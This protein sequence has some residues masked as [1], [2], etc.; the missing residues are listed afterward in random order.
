MTGYCCSMILYY[1]I[2]VFNF[3]ENVYNNIQEY[4]S[5]TVNKQL[6]GRVL[7]Y[8]MY[9][10]GT[11]D[12]NYYTQLYNV[13]S[14]Y[15]RIKLIILN[16][17]YHNYYEQ[18]SVFTYTDVYTNIENLTSFMI[19]AVIISYIKN[20]YLETRI[21]SYKEEDYKNETN[22]T[23][24]SRSPKFVFALVVSQEGDTEKEHDFTKEF[25]QHITDIK[26]SPLAVSDFIYIIKSKY[27]RNLDDKD[28]FKLKVMMDNDFNEVL[29]NNN[30]KLEF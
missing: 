9:T 17:I 15:D 2:Y 1:F 23:A 24:T 3:F 20:G 11:Q 26:N 25:N 16:L 14:L 12:D 30:D 27:K 10:K 6:E 4:I 7:Y 21:L 8:A 28:N 5:L 19:D 18:N 22:D 29:Y 13:T